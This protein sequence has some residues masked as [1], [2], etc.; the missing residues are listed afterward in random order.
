MDSKRRGL[1]L[2]LAIV[3][4]LGVFQPMVF[5]EP[6]DPPVEPSVIPENV[7]Q[8][9]DKI[10]GTVSPGTTGT[11]KLVDAV[12]GEPIIGT[13]EQEITGEIS[14]DGKITLSIDYA[15]DGET[16]AIQVTETGKSPSKGGEVKIDKKILTPPAIQFYKAVTNKLD[17][18]LPSDAKKDDIVSLEIGNETK[19]KIL[20]EEDI[21]GGK[22]TFEGL[23]L[24]LDTKVNAQIKNKLDY[25]SHK[26]EAV[27]NSPGALDYE[28]NVKPPVVEPIEAGDIE[29]KGSAD[30]T[31]DLYLSIN[32]G[33]EE[34]VTVTYDANGD[35]TYTLPAAAVVGQKITARTAKVVD[36]VEKTSTTQTYYVF[37]N[38][39]IEGK[40]FNSILTGSSFTDHGF[41]EKNGEK[42]F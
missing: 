26:T 23:D 21:Q 25:S 38:D 13:N 35:F 22:I 31:G 8:E 33:A 5:A 9:K 7:K 2:L 6:G 14:D 4:I 29:I 18:I 20:T 28:D 37:S 32:E 10:T 19:K 12:L 27:Y 16:V 41:V 17:V 1:C 24:K 39:T 3:I 40:R 42:Y 34:K 36:G 15:N 11:A 30:S